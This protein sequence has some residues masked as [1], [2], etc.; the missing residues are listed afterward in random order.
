MGGIYTYIP[1][2]SLAQRTTFRWSG[3]TRSSPV[4]RVEMPTILMVPGEIQPGFRVEKPLE[5]T[6][7]QDE[8]GLVI[9]SDDRFYVYGEGDSLAEA[10]NDYKI[11]LIEY[12]EILE[13][14]QDEPT[15]KLFNYL[16][17]YIKKI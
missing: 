16:R 6:S 7:L 15:Q 5:L 4:K 3:S 1:S 10:Y 13:M 9:I 17:Q 12:Y 8:N 2:D 11:S 14:H